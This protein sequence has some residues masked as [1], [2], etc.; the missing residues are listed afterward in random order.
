MF[1]IL[2][3]GFINIFRNPLVP[4]Q[5]SEGTRPVDLVNLKS[6]L[7]GHSNPKTRQILISC[8]TWFSWAW[9]QFQCIDV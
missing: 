6:N 7:M 1:R 8:K 4:H 3:E 5:K 9:P 2:L